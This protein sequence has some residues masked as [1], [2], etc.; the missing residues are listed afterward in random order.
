MH[1]DEAVIRR[2]VCKLVEEEQNEVVMVLHSAG[3]FLGTAAIEGLSRKERNVRELL[4]GVVGFVFLS[5]AVMDV[6]HVHAT[7]PFFDINASPKSRSKHANKLT[8]SRPKV[9]KCIA[10]SQ[11]EVCSMILTKK[12]RRN[13]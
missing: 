10:W 4:G 9:E 7:L 12:R 2:V 5:A 1:D 3:G 11:K 13:G 6:G 8:C